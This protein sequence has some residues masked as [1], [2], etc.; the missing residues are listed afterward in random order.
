MGRGR[1]NC[2]VNRVQGGATADSSLK[3]HVPFTGRGQA[4]PRATAPHAIRV[5]DTLSR[6]CAHGGFECTQRMAR[7]ALAKRQRVF[8]DVGVGQIR[9]VNA[10]CDATL[11]RKIVIARGGVVA[12]FRNVACPCRILRRL[13]PTQSRRGRAPQVADDGVLEADVCIA[14]RRGC[15]GRVVVQDDPLGRR[16]NAT[17]RDAQQ[18][19]GR[20]GVLRCARGHAS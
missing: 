18:G 10:S 6:P 7:T 12:D 17:F 9:Q 3:V 11:W 13:N 20:Q 8:H 16:P 5:G 19:Q 2:H 14:L 15:G 1:L 4:Q